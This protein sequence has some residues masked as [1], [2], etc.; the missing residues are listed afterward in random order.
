MVQHISQVPSG[1]RFLRQQDEQ[2]QHSRLLADGGSL[3]IDFH[4]DIETESSDGLAKAKEDANAIVTSGF[5]TS[6]RQT[7]YIY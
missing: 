1:R 5:S 7:E 4:V 6:A 3:K 2:L